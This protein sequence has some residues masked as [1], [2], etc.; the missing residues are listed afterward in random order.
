MHPAGPAEGEQGELPGV[1]AALHAYDAQG[2]DHLRVGHPHDAQGR[3][4]GVQSQPIPQ[5]C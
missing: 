3:L 1:E 5:G 4:L 2:P